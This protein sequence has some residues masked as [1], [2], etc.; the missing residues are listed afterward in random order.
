MRQTIGNSHRRLNSAAAY[1][2]VP[3]ALLLLAV[4]ALFHI[5]VEVVEGDTLA[6]DQAFLL[7]LRDA[8]DV[9]L[10]IGPTW[11]RRQC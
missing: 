2:V 1:R 10:P 6:W 7:S 11:V 5:A 8:D 3:F 4:A 9:A